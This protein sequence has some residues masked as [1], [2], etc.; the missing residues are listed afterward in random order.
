M[1]E[2]FLITHISHLVLAY[3]SSIIFLGINLP[4]VSPILLCSAL[5]ELIRPV[6]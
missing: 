4:N 1:I 3:C 2:R 6:V 5:T